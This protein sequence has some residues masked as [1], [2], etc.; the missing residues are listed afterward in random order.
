MSI[1][2]ITQSAVPIISAGNDNY[3]TV[4]GSTAIGVLGY[5]FIADIYINGILQITLKSFPD[6]KFGVGVF[7]TKNLI[8]S[9]ISFDFFP[10]VNSPSSSAYPAPNS[11]ARVFM[12]YGEEYTSG[13]TLVQRRNLVSGNTYVFINASL[14]YADPMASNLSTLDITVTAAWF[15]KLKPTAAFVT[16]GPLSPLANMNP[17]Y[18]G[19]RQL[20]YFNSN[21]STPLFGSNA[22][23]L[24]YAVSTYNA[25]RGFINSF[26]VRNNLSGSTD[27]QA[28]DVSYNTLAG[29][30]AGPNVTVI[31]GAFPVISANTAYIKINQENQISGTSAVNS[32]A[33]VFKIV[34]DC[35]RWAPYAYTVSWLNE[36]GGFD[37]WYFN[38]KNLTTQGKEVQRYKKTKG[39]PNAQ[40][41]YTE[42]TQSRAVVIGTTVLQDTIQ[43]SSGFLTDAQ[44]VFLKSL[45]TSPL[46]Y[47]TDQNGMTVAVTID[48]NSYVLNKVLL[49]KIYSLVFNVKPA[50]NDYRQQF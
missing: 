25:S 15:T 10:N 23:A 50:Y 22:Y 38:G 49:T 14:P 30:T 8:S 41:G 35:G 37:S 6:P 3:S 17:L 2:L 26:F 12:T 40:G 36:F 11:S 32:T 16:T 18:V 48:E 33:M 4:S 43:L 5:K 24:G 46:I 27:V 1:S 31:A 44:V 19:Q 29:L 20:L 45:F 28:I 42:T 39:A 9:F 7:N 47:L 21:G 34:T 13:S